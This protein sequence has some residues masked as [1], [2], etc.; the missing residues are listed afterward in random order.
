MG[1]SF[2]GCDGFLCDVRG[3]TLAPQPLPA[4]NEAG[5]G[6]STVYIDEVVVCCR[7]TDNSK[8]VG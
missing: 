4:T 5:C 1:S 6:A 8:A 7:P 3:M 2:W